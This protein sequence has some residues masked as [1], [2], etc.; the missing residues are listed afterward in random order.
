MQ[1]R[2]TLERREA[3]EQHELY[4]VTQR[5]VQLVRAATRVAR[6]RRL[7]TRHADVRRGVRLQ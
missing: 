3:R 7:V 4:H 5:H 1:T 2:L 6:A